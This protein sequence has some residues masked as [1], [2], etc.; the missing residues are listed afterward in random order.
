MRLHGTSL[1][2]VKLVCQAAVSHV[3]GR[4]HVQTSAHVPSTTDVVEA[5]D[6]MLLPGASIIIVVFSRLV[7]AEIR[8]V[9]LGAARWYCS[10]VDAR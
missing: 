10:C 5:L 4:W 8:F 9:I 7:D 1:C 2:P 6:E 3:S